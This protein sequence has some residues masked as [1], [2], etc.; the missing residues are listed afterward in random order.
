MSHKFQSS[1]FVDECC[2]EYRSSNNDIYIIYILLRVEFSK[3][4]M[5]VACLT[6][7][8][9]YDDFIHFSIEILF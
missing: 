5:F 7:N 4:N 2:K 8:Q 3:K 1:I 6:L 9:V